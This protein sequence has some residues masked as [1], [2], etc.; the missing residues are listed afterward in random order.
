VADGHRLSLL[1]LTPSRWHGKSSQRVRLVRLATLL[2]TLCNVADD[3]RETEFEDTSIPSILYDSASPE[4]P[5][6]HL[7]RQTS[8]SVRMLWTNAFPP[9]PDPLVERR[10]ALGCELEEGQCI[11]LSH[12]VRSR[13]TPSISPAFR[14]ATQLPSYSPTS[15]ANVLHWIRVALHPAFSD[16]RGGEP[17]QHA[18]S[19]TTKPE[20]QRHLPVPQTFGHAKQG[21]DLLAE[22]AG[23][24]VCGSVA[25]FMPSF[26]L[27]HVQLLRQC[28]QRMPIYTTPIQ[29]CADS[30]RLSKCSVRRRPCVKAALPH[31]SRQGF[32]VPADAFQALDRRGRP[33]RHARRCVRQTCAAK[34]L[35]PSTR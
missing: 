30:A 26:P 22:A 18:S 32:D 2:G 24:I 1:F 31:R 6:H 27:R 29:Q 4:V 35:T 25:S 17:C 28:S 11:P 10:W 12:Q 23:D 20:D 16:G 5:G 13:L 14:F 7:K 3:P 15:P 8:L 9:F 33:Q 34:R 19:G 21:A